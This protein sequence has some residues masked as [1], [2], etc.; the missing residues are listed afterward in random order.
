VTQ[1]VY[2]LALGYE[3]NCSRK[4]CDPGRGEIMAKSSGA[5]QGSP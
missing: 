2:G 1:R 4:N 3:I 5:L